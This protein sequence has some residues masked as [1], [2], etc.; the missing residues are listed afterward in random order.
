M[1]QRKTLILATATAALINFS[2][3]ALAADD[4]LSSQLSEARQEGSLWTALA[5]NRHLNPFRIGVDVENGR[6]VLT[7]KVESE[8]DRE[9]AEQIA[10]GTEGIREVDNRLQVDGQTQREDKSELAQRFDDATTTATVKYKLLWNRNTEGLDIDVDN[11][12]G[13]ITLSGTAQS[14]A[15]KELAGRLAANTEGVREVDNQIKVTGQPGTV[16]RSKEAARDTGDAISDAWITSK[17]KAS[18]LYSRE[19]DGLAIDVDTKDGEVQLRGV[20]SD[21]AEK[22]LV[23]ETARSVRGVRE[24]DAS[25]LKV[26]G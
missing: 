26:A 3:P 8:V 18:L 25:A 1:Y 24:V 22:D 21:S 19:I 15:A 17:V 23:V 10:L 13:V 11:R 4:D 2:W 12:N 14:D 9:L 7:G 5:L 6:A 16:A 20:V